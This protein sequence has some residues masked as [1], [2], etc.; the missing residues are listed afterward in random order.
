MNEDNEDLHDGTAQEDATETSPQPEPPEPDP[1]AESPG[2][3]KRPSARKRIY[4]GAAIAGTIIGVSIFVVMAAFMIIDATQSKPLAL[5]PADTAAAVIIDLEA[6]RKG[7]QHFPGEYWDFIDAVQA[8][9]DRAFRTSELDTSQIGLLLH[10]TPDDGGAPVHLARGDLVPQYLADSWEER[11]LDQDSYRGRPIWQSRSRTTTIFEDR[12]IAAASGPAQALNAQIRMLEGDTRP[13]SDFDRHDLKDIL[14]ALGGSPARAAATGGD[15]AQLCLQT[16]RSC[17]GYGAAFRSFD[18]QTADTRLN[19][20]LL[21]SND[22][23]AQRALEDYDPAETL[24]KT[25][26]LTI[27]TLSNPTYG[28][29]RPGT[30]T[31]DKLTQ[32]GRLLLAE[33]TISEDPFIQRRSPPTPTHAPASTTAPTATSAPGTSPPISAHY[34]RR[35]HQCLM[36]NPAE[37]E[38]VVELITLNEPE[39]RDIFEAIFQ[40]QDAFVATIMLAIQDDPDLATF[41][42]YIHTLSPPYCNLPDPGPQT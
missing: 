35:L 30:I 23:V 17:R 40:D 16:I 25:A 21:F 26:A 3:R 34:L 15:L 32:D 19:A 1:H 5:I 39:T 33:I 18:S 31:V 12:K 6:I 14:D 36:E 41:Y 11:G 20:V 37:T 38:L 9:I 2:G 22:R 4:V 27:A 24:L 42:R 29:L 28:A 7:H 10:I 13:L 8:D